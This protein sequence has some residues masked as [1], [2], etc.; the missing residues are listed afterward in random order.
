MT[1]PFGENTNTSSANMSTFRLWKK[2]CASDSC[3]VS[4][5]RRIQA[6]FSSSPGLVPS[7]LPVLYFQCA[8]TPYSAVMCIS[9][10]RICTSNGMPS[11]P[12]TVVCTL[13]YIFGFGVLM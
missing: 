3:C 7:P 9:H 2:S 11:E 13:W 4:S 6:N 10:V 8:A 12:M 5:R 1:S